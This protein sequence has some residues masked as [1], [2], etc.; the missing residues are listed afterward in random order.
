VTEESSS[1]LHRIAGKDTVILA[2]RGPLDVNTPVAT[3]SGWKLLSALQIGDEVYGD[4]GLPTKVIDTLDYG[5]AECWEVVLSD[6]TS[7]VCDDSHK[8]AVRRMGTDPKG[9]WRTVTL[10]EIRCFMTDGMKGNYRT[11]VSRTVRWAQEGEKPWLDKR[12]Y[13]RYQVP[14]AEPIQYPERDLPIDPYLLGVLIGDGALTTGSVRFHKPEQ[15]LVDRIQSTLPKDYVVRQVGAKYGD[16]RIVHQDGKHRK[17]REVLDNPHP[18][19][20]ALKKLGLW[21][22]R[23]HEKFIPKEY[24]LA[25]VEQR[26][27]LLQGILDT[28]GTCKK[29]ASGG[30]V[31]FSTSS[32]D[33]IEDFAELVRSLGGIVTMRKTSNTRYKNKDGVFVQCKLAYK[34]GIRLP[35]GIKPFYIS[36]KAELYKG[37]SIGRTNGGLVRSIVDIRPAG[38]RQIR[39]ITVDNKQ[40]R[41]VVKDYVVSPNSAKS[42]QVGLFTAWAIGIHAEQKLPLK[43]LYISYTV[44]VARPKS[45]AIKNTICSKRYQEIFP[46]VRIKKGATSNEYWSIDY[47]HAGIEETGD[48]QFTLCCAGLKGSIT[49]KRSHLCL[50]GDTL[51]LTDKGQISIEEVYESPGS[52]RVAVRDSKSDQ[53]VWSKI[54]AVTR[55]AAKGIV[56]IET[57]SGCKISATPEHPFIEASGRTKRA[58]ALNQQDTL[59][60]LSTWKSD[61]E[62]PMLQWREKENS[63]NLQYLSCKNKKHANNHGMSCVSKGISIKDSKTESSIVNKARCCSLQSCMCGSSK[64]ETE[65]KGLSVLLQDIQTIKSSDCVLQSEMRILQSFS[66][67]ERGK[68]QQLQTWMQPI[69]IP[70]NTSSHTSAGYEDVCC[71]QIRREATSSK[72]RHMEK[73]FVRTSHR[74]QSREQYPSEFNNIVSP[75]PHGTSS[76]NGQDWEAEPISRVEFFGDREEYVYD[77]ETEDGNHNFIA[78]GLNVLNCLIDD[79]IKSAAEIAN[80][81][82]RKLMQDNWNSVIAPTMFEGARAICLGTR[83]RHDDLFATTFVEANGWK[84][85]VQQALITD[86]QGNYESYWPEMWSV[87]YLLKKKKT[88]PI[89]FSFQYMNQIVRQSEL[90]LSPDLLIRSEIATEFDTIGIGVDLSSGLKEKNDYTVMTLGGRIGDKIHIID[91]RRFRV[92]GN[93]E[94]L[95]KMMELL[96]D[97]NLLTQDEEG[98][99]YPTMNVVDI[100]SEAVQYQAS[101]EADFKRICIAEHELHNLKWHPVKGFRSD[102]LARFRGIMGMFEQRK[103]VFNRYRGFMSM[104]DELTNFGTS[105]HD[106]CVDSLVHLVNGLMRRGSLEMDY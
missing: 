53:I 27:A 92:M 61:R 62:V 36:S 5:E 78:N 69:R 87:E 89:S 38:K 67:N 16:W 52:Y 72:E 46:S 91:Y 51:V 58:G 31:S 90:S 41:F 96:A 73:P 88:A 82:I 22:C 10:Q 48:E 18:I 66:K 40:H 80:P 105:S 45:A 32:V 26:E 102:K 104:F 64:N 44:D 50:V 35:E 56:E 33:L 55:R 106:D 13:A 63:E 6:G 9:T 65:T 4:D 79:C 20:E 54:R 101:L 95:D 15:E 39:C 59:V 29:Q 24:L 93:L 99:F 1:C 21:G 3:P 60:R 98:N 84:Q 103:I 74:S 97:W 71:V 94:K 81:E 83:F 8:W 43:I 85:I 100:W 34:C 68:E 30:G 70:E 28:D 11:G 47:K 37:P 49:S 86:D 7:V 23:S 19:V 25:S 2:P 12:G 14:I 42:T 57:A 75:V 77:L 76:H 17:R